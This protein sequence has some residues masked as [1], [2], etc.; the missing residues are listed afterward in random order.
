MELDMVLMPLS[1]VA[2]LT[3]SLVAIYQDN[4]KRL[5]AYSSVAQIGYMVL[6]ISLRARCWASPPGSCTSS[7]TRS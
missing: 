2:I 4:V 1:L 5:L 6:G 7:T 3:M